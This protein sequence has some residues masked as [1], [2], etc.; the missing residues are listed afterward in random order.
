MTAFESFVDEIIELSGPY[1]DRD[2]MMFAVAS[3]IMHLP[4]QRSSVPKNYFVRSLRKVAANQVA[5]QAFQDVKTR[6]AEAQ[7]AAQEAEKQAQ[8]DAASNEATNKEV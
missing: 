4:P 5:G 1:A 6:Q 3:I 2:S 7:K 8:Q